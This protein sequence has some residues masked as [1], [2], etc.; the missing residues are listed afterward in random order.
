MTRFI[1]ITAISIFSLNLSAQDSNNTQR[2][3]TIKLLEEKVNNLQQQIE[4][5]EAHLKDLLDAKKDEIEKVMKE[6]EDALN[7]R[8]LLY[9]GFFFILL[10]LT[11]WF[12][13]WIGKKEIRNIVGE[14]AKS[15]V[16]EE[17]ANKF[18]KDVIDIK[19]TQWGEPAIRKIVEELTEVGNKAKLDALELEEVKEKYVLFKEDMEELKKNAD[20]SKTTPE[21]KKKVKEFNEIAHEF[22]TEEN[23]SSDDWFWKGVGAMNESKFTEA[24]NYFSK[25]INL[26]PDAYA[27]LNRGY[28]Y[29][30]LKEYQNAVEDANKGIEIDPRNA[31]AWNNRGSSK[32]ELNKYEDAIIDLNE[33]IRLNPQSYT[34]WSIRGNSKN[35]LGKYEDAIVDLNEAIRLNPQDDVAWNN[36]G[37]A[38]NSL[39]KY[40]DAINDLDETIKLNPNIPQGYKHR[41]YSNYKLGNLKLSMN[42]V[43]KA[44]ELDPNYKEAIE[45]RDE[46]QKTIG[47]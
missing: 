46:I 19:L 29:H 27:Y 21:E 23:F 25:S 1:L 32:N 5:S 20:I 22:K 12:L 36:R 37:F 33:A 18:S 34:S 38:K 2:D 42:D 39:G 4:K 3:F 9:S 10:S 45:L 24:I 17:L 40:L 13:N 31:V 8:M 11:V 16:E 7:T 35:N 26:A 44:I 41:A 30:K 6:K 43:N 14:F 28:C 47:N 15:K